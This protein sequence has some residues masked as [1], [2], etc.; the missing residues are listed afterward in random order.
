MV[1]DIYEDCV[2]DVTWTIVRDP[3]DDFGRKRS[4][5]SM[6]QSTRCR[7]EVLRALGA[8]NSLSKPERSK[9][10]A[11]GGSARG[12]GLVSVERCA[13]PTD[14]RSGFG[15]FAAP[16]TGV[17]DGLGRS[18]T[19]DVVLVAGSVGPVPCDPEHQARHSENSQ[20][21][22]R[23]EAP[24]EHDGLGGRGVAGCPVGVGFQATV[25]EE[26]PEVDERADGDEHSGCTCD[27]CPAGDGAHQLHCLC[28]SVPDQT[29]IVQHE[30][31]RLVPPPEARLQRWR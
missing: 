14:E 2:D 27:R 31:E 6:F 10:Q 23:D 22:D 3:A 7:S 30:P 16:P 29:R 25:S 19:E 26:D 28:I 9:R 13:A 24:D 8:Q 12:A 11:V 17:G 21:W 18:L 4:F 20:E 1:R 5:L 15:G